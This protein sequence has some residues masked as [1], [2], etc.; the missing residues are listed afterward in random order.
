MWSEDYKKWLWTACLDY[1]ASKRES[2]HDDGVKEICV[3]PKSGVKECDSSV[4]NE[5]FG[6]MWDEINLKD[7][8][9]ESGERAC[10]PVVNTYTSE[11]T[12]HF[13]EC[14]QF[15]MCSQHDLTF[16]IY[17]NGDYNFDYSDIGFCQEESLLSPEITAT[18]QTSC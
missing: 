10:D 11:W 13:M 4:A 14:L 5:L 1:Y 7:G 15:R 17:N 18:L 9:V 2:K 8:V 16:N 12:G 6:S 3:Q